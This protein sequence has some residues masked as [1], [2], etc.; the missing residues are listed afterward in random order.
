M[1]NHQLEAIFGYSREEVVGLRTRALL[2]D[3]QAHQEYERL[4]KH[5]P[6][7]PAAETSLR[8]ELR[9]RRRDG[10]E[11]V[12]EAGLSAIEIDGADYVLANIVDISE[13]KRTEQALQAARDGLGEAQ[14]IAR[15]GSVEWH[16]ADGRWTGSAEARR[17]F[18][19]APDDVE[20]PMRYIH[21]DD[22]VAVLSEIERVLASKEPHYEF[23]CRVI[24]A[25]FSEALMRA[26]G[27][28]TYAPERGH[29]VHVLGTVQDVTEARAVERELRWLRGKLY[30]TDRVVRA[31]VLTGSLAHELNQPLAAILSNAQAGLRMIANGAAAATEIVD[32][33]NDIVRDDKRAAAVI[34]GLR[35]MLRQKETERVPLD[36]AQAIG[37]LLEL[38]RG[39]ILAAKAELVT[40]FEPGCV[41]EADRTQF[42]QVVLNLVQNAIDAMSHPDIIKRRLTITTRTAREGTVLIAVADSGPGIAETEAKT[43]FNVFWTTK[44]QGMGMGLAVCRNIVD[45]HGGRIW[46]EPAADGVGAR[47]CV[48]LPMPASKADDESRRQRVGNSGE[49]RA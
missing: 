2:P 35:S 12:V 8:H 20:S 1:V 33:L 17:I 31:S 30:H 24:R 16:V 7:L 43:V 18:G 28:V 10:S 44:E 39:E 3:W 34:N 23:E 29:A 36:V 26:K 13:R 6:D 11:I 40:E 48:E 27:E 47:F 4:G 19:S 15:L 37:N 49:E 42:D 38:L 45:S 5:I 46:L 22:Q 21:P 25:D 14:R 9:G 41:V 32:I